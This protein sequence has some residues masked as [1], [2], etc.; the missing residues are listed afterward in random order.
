MLL[1]FFVLS[2]LTRLARF[3]VTVSTIPKDATGKSKYFEGFPIPTSLTIVG[4]MAY[5]LS[6]GHVLDN[7]PGGILG[8]GQFWEFH[9]ISLLFVGWGCAMVSRSIHVPKP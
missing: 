1:S 5:C 8:E 3:N 6:Q 2:G 9:P 7:V 4:M